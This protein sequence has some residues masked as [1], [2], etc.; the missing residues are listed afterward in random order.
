MQEATARRGEPRRPTIE[1]GA[2]SIGEATNCYGASFGERS[3]PKKKPFAARTVT[4]P[5]KS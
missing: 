2:E 3:E 1:E 5:L 4:Y